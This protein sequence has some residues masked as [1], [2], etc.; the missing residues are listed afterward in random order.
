MS[1]VAK[2]INLLLLEDNPG[3]IFLMKFYLDELAPGLYEIEN[4]ETLKDAHKKMNID[5][6]DVVLLDLHVP[7]SQGLDTLIDSVEKFP[8]Q[9]FVVLTTMSDSDLGIEA[10]KNGAQDFLIKGK[11]DGAAL[12]SSIKFA[13]ERSK[14]KVK[15]QKYLEILNTVA[16][17]NDISN[18]IIHPKTHIFEHSH[19]L[20]EYINCDKGDIDTLSEFVELSSD[21]KEIEEAVEKSIANPKTIFEVAI[22]IDENP[23][24]LKVKKMTNGVI[25]TLSKN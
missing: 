10:V 11:I 19:N 12:D 6:F 18:F 25:G 2:K 22:K 17:M 4:A 8:S 16:E 23:F 3:D 21:S 7:D 13:I 15:I 20:S 9:T 14:M 1:N 24:L 5:H